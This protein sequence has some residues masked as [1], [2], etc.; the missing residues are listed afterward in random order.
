MR[1][2][3]LAEVEELIAVGFHIPDIIARTFFQELAEDI[4]VALNNTLSHCLT[5]CGLRT[6]SKRVSR[7]L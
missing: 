6:M 4:L 3:L 1:C 7:P 5:V 2:E